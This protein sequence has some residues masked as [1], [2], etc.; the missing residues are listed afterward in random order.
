MPANITNK[1]TQAILHTL[2]YSDIFDYPLTVPE[3]HQYLTGVKA[4]FEEVTQALE[5]GPMG[6]TGNYFTLPGREGIVSIRADREARSQKLFPLALRY[7]RILSALPYIRMVALTG[8]LAM[9]NIEDGKDIDYLIVTAPN[10]LWTCRAL[11]LLV[12]RFARFEGIRLCPNYLIT[13]K[14]LAL[15]DQSLYAA[16]ELAQMIPLSGMEIYTK[17]RHMNAWTNE[18][19]PNAQGLP[20]SF[21]VANTRSDFQHFLEIIF[22][23]LPVRLFEKWEMNRKIKK[24][25]RE[26]FS[27]SESSF[28][29]DVCKGHADMHGETTE[30]ELRRRLHDFAPAHPVYAD[31]LN[32]S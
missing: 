27:S 4:S 5:D 19:L 32:D 8:S 13:E 24:L 30:Y 26:Q 2:S 16:H 18:Y 14:A 15:P 9:R 31:N 12:A 11:A 17:M 25:S 22:N 29:E 21:I 6:R 23:L 28:S 1:L 10:H 20:E 3:V 7:G